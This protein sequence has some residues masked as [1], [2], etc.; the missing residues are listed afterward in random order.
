MITCELKDKI[1]CDIVSGAMVRTIDINE[2]EMNYNIDRFTYDA[3]LEQFERYGFISQ[4]HSLGGG[5]LIT[6]KAEAHDFFNRGGFVVQEEILKG[7]IEKLG[8]EL[9]LLSKEL[10]PKYLEKSNIIMSIANNI[11]SVFNIF[12]TPS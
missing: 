7:N 11:L 5:R 1:L 4:K 10:A 8:L 2:S 6:V 12:N 3:V 9:E